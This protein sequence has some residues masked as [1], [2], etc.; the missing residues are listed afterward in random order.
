MQ[1]RWQS[2][3]ISKCDLFHV[4]VT[5]RERDTHSG[6]LSHYIIS[7][8]CRGSQSGCIYL[9]PSTLRQEKTAGPG[10][11]NRARIG[12]WLGEIEV[13]KIYTRKR[14]S[15]PHWWTDKG[16]K[17]WMSFKD[18]EGQTYIKGLE[19]LHQIYSALNRNKLMLL[20]QMNSK[21]TRTKCRHC[22][23]LQTTEIL[24]S[25]ASLMSIFNEFILWPACYL[26]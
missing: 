12:K 22:K 20:C 3:L 11:E 26:M 1:H 18:K 24:N 21:K 23:F 9:P 2:A 5:K 25:C 7:C 15:D 14:L 16:L 6:L 10:K 8:G 19:A 13:G 17:T 4:T